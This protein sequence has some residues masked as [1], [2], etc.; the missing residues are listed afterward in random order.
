MA[1]P[2]C[3][4][5]LRGRRS[6][7]ALCC[8]STRY[9]RSGCPSGNGCA[10]RRMT[11]ASAPKNGPVS[12]PPAAGAAVAESLSFAQAP[13]DPS[14][15]FICPNHQADADQ[16]LPGCTEV[17]ELPLALT[18]PAEFAEERLSRHGGPW[19]IVAPPT[20]FGGRWSAR[21]EDVV[22]DE[23]IFSE[24]A[25]LR[26]AYTLAHSA[27]ESTALLLVD[28]MVRGSEGTFTAG[29]TGA[30][31]AFNASHALL[32]LCNRPALALDSGVIPALASVLSEDKSASA[33]ARVVQ[34]NHAAYALGDILAAVVATSVSAD[35]SEQ[36]SQAV[37]T[38]TALIAPDVEPSVLT[39]SIQ[40]A[41]CEALGNIGSALTAKIAFLSDPA[42]SSA[43]GGGVQPEAVAVDST[44]GLQALWGQVEAALSAAAFEPPQPPRAAARLASVAA[45][46]KGG[47][48]SEED[49]ALIKKLKATPR[50]DSLISYCVS[51]A[52]SVR[53]ALRARSL[54]ASCRWQTRHARGHADSGAAQDGCEGRP[55]VVEPAA[56]WARHGCRLRHIIGQRHDR[57]IPVLG[58]PF[59][60]HW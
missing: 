17:E 9:C 11:R 16:G 26:A 60:P 29:D 27:T 3:T 28:I 1:P 51:S 56:A 45:Q 39:M 31:K 43:S 23:G 55:E 35:V 52:H 44:A 15:T 6:S 34:R 59:G 12:A 57:Q 49:E 33:V 20:A 2:G 41:V 58:K 54:T 14:C 46:L 25:A 53:P 30:I 5:R 48:L 7:T 8:V 38:L 32:M 21:P 18:S 10:V 13:V 36:V 37:A 50:G 47:E 24:I 22:T 19:C 40:P 4:A 42:G